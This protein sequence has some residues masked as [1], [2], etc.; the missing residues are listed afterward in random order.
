MPRARSLLPLLALPLLLAASDAPA[1]LSTRAQKALEGRTA[2]EPVACISLT[3]ARQ[4]SIIDATAI[5]Y[6]ESAK[7]W[8]V[9]QPDNG[10]CGQLN[11]NRILITRTSGTQLCGNDIVTIAEAGSPITYGACGLGRFVPYRK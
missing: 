6:K 3:R 2:G 7:L 4:S 5:I 11:P 1:P 8:Y 10:R 9:N